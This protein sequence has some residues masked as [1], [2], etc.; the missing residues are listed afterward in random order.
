M[1]NK[2][3]PSKRGDPAYRNKQ[4]PGKKVTT[5]RPIISDS[6]TTLVIKCGF[7]SLL[8]DLDW[9]VEFHSNSVHLSKEASYKNKYTTS[10]TFFSLFLPPKI[11]RI[12]T[13][14]NDSSLRT[15]LTRSPDDVSGLGMHSSRT[16]ISRMCAAVKSADSVFCV[17]PNKWA[18]S[19]TK[20]GI[21]Y[22]LPTKCSSSKHART[23][24]DPSPVVR[25]LRLWSKRRIRHGNEDF[26][27]IIPISSCLNKNLTN[28]SG[29]ARNAANH[30]SESEIFCIANKYPRTKKN[31]QNDGFA[32]CEFCLF[33]YLFIFVCKMR[34]YTRRICIYNNKTD[35]LTYT[36]QIHGH[37]IKERTMRIAESMIGIF[38]F[39]QSKHQR[40]S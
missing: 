3:N 36:R 20:F 33:I 31:W 11:A 1:W 37:A 2:R 30:F 35:G 25:L 34:E 18:F 27:T 29:N 17:L 32:R 19:V 38:S 6:Q 5:A 28:E 24:S 13:E 15:K 7:C 14:R 12:C 9:P 22:F 39:L 23:H 26:G 21:F 10:F 40:V 8:R 16:Y 4:V